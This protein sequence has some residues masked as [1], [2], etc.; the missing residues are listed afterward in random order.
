MKGCLYGLLSR[1][2]YFLHKFIASLA[3]G[4]LGNFKKRHPPSRLFRFIMALLLL[5][6]VYI[7]WQFYQA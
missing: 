3:A 6:F 1:L 2:P 5:L 7:A 4:V